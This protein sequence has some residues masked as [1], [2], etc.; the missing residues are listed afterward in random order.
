MALKRSDLNKILSAFKSDDE[1]LEGSTKALLDLF[2]SEIDAEKDKFDELSKEF[3]DYKKSNHGADDADEWKSKF[4]KE[5]DAFKA[6][7]TEQASKAS[8]E[9]KADSYKALLKEAGVSEKRINSIIKVTD[10]DNMEFKDGVFTDA[11]KL[12]DAIKNDWS[13]F[14]VTTETRGADTQ[15]PQ[16]NDNGGKYTSKNEIMKIT[17]RAERRQAIKENPQL[18]ISKQE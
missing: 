10:L 3:E 6:Y 16:Q 15:K 2:H 17:D 8:K 7:K 5:R 4:E 11:D 1:T 12:K 14:I 9:L 13:D 18:F